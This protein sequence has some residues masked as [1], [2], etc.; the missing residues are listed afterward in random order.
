[1]HITN[2]K[3]AEH[4]HSLLYE[5][6]Y[7]PLKINKLDSL[8]ISGDIANK[9]TLEEYKVA[10]QF[11]DNLCQDF[12]L[13][14]KQI[15]IVPG[16]HD[17]NWEQT[18]KAFHPK[19]NKE[20]PKIYIE[21]DK[22]KQRFV[23]F[24]EF[25]KDIKGQS[26]PLD[27]DKQ[28]TLD[29]LPKQH[30]LILGLN[31]AWQLDHDDK[32]CASINMDALNKALTEIKYNK[33]Y[34]NCIKIAVWHHPVNSECEGK[35]SDSAFLH[36]LVNYGFRFFLNGHM[37]IREAETSNYRYEKIYQ[38]EKIYGICAGTFGV[39][40]S[41]LSKATLWQYNLL[42]FNTDTLTVHP[43]WRQQEN[44]PW[45]SGDNYTINIKS[46]QKTIDQDKLTRIIDKLKQD[47]GTIS[48][49]YYKIYN[50]G[51]KEIIYNALEGITTII[52]DFII[53]DRA[54]IYF[55]NESERLSSIVD[56]K[57][58]YLEIAVLIGQGFAGKVA[59]SKKIHISGIEECLN[60]DETVKQSKRTGYT[61]YTLLTYPL[62]DEQEN[63]V[64]VIQLINKLKQSNNKK[65]S[66]E[67]RI[68]QSGFKEE[69]KED[70]NKLADQ[71]RPILEEFKSSYKMAHEMQGFIDYTKAIHKL[72]KASTKCN[73]LEEIC[74]MV[75][76]VAE[77]F[78]Q[79]DR[80]TLWL[81]DRQRKEL[82][83]TIISKD[84]SPEEKIIKFGDGY[85]GE[86]AAEKKIKII[87]FD[88]YEHQDSQMSKKTDKETGYRTCSLM[89]MPILH[90]DQL[91]G[92][93]QL[94]NKRKP[95]VDIEYDDQKS[96][97]NPLDCFQNS[98]TDKDK[99]L[100]KQLNY[101]IATAIS[102][103][104]QSITDKADN[105]L[106]EFLSKITELAKDELCSHRVTIFLLDQEAKEFWSIIKENIEIRVPIN[107]GIVG[108]AGRKKPGEFVKARNVDKDNNPRF[109][110]A[111][112]QDKK[113][114]YTTY[115]LLAIPLFNEKE[116][117]V[118]VVEFVNKLKNIQSRI[119]QDIAP[120]DKV[121]K[122]KVDMEGF[123]D[124]D[125]KKF[126]EISYIMLKFLEGFK[127]LY[128][129]TRRK[130]GELRLKNAITTLSEINI[131]AE[132]SQI[133]EKVQE[134]AKKL[135][136]ADRSTLW[137]LDRKSNKLWAHFDEDGES[138]RKEVPVGTG[139][140]GKV[141]EHCKSLNISFERYGEPNYAISLESDDENSYLIYSLICMP[142]L[143]SDK[144]LLAVIQLDNKKKPGNFSDDN[145]EDY[146][147]TQVP[148]LFQ[149][150][151]TKED[152]KLLNEFNIAAAS[153]LSQIELFEEMHKIASS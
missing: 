70:L 29:H 105:I 148:E 120:K 103:V 73:D 141:A 33:D 64:A 26:Y 46:N 94:V 113:N 48:N 102:E 53:A 119:K 24:S 12:S 132:R 143:N 92:V 34:Q 55:L 28:Y 52:K 153:Y 116:E 100:I 75:T 126:S 149:A 101:F 87:P 62:L 74:K 35:I 112:K 41:E 47:M 1:M 31:S 9:S 19:N 137:H 108:E 6:L 27:D 22:Y 72:S 40:T 69:D 122:D 97:K 84:G 145:H 131:D 20:K 136:N 99:K 109:N 79:A 86:A 77:D 88:L 71:I 95:G 17:L 133:F 83:A 65:A 139:Y 25:Y 115:N 16:N 43:R 18:K 63:L 15:I 66:L 30:L 140:V 117:L 138:Q 56:K 128:E 106:Y 32:Y 142:I 68:D 125:P 23:H 5:D 42:E 121:D 134:E 61:T 98:F 45:E 10:K 93:L 7:Y 80:T 3:Q 51:F 57:G 146:D 114:D 150:N 39:H 123:T 2:L 78:M 85:V 90:V 11:I 89:S 54:T 118:A 60:S 8:I 13:E 50:E 129:T 76:K 104:N 81:A 110:E 135:V 111:K 37:H 82:Q 152:E 38:E 49:D 151:F 58:E 91:V 124:T 67:E 59:K 107:K 44:S 14:P 36:R 4:W 130:Q 147:S 96:I 127:A 144:E 21:K